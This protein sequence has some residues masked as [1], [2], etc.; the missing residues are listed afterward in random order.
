MVKIFADGADLNKLEEYADD[1][2]IEGFTT[3]PSLMRKADIKDYKTFA[4]TVLSLVKGKPVSFEIL[5]D[6][7]HTME[8]QARE[9]QSWG[10]NVYV[11][12]PITNTAGESSK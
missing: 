11:K 7:F 2:R 4:K 5:A 3:N 9:I 12:I 8:R 1:S 10:D 6:D